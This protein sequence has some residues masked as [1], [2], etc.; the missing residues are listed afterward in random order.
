[1]T[2]LANLKE[3]GEKLIDIHGQHDNQ[4]LLNP[5]MHIDLLDNFIGKELANVKALYLDNLH[6]YKRLVNE[7]NS[8]FGDEKERTRR[9]DF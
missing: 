2:T 9:I 1:M 7:L 5:A 4:S 8:N 6:E 3:M